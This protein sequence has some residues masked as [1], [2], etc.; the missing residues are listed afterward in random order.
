MPFPRCSCLATVFFNQLSI[1]DDDVPERTPDIKSNLIK[2]ATNANKSAKQRMPRPA[3][4]TAN[5]VHEV[6]GDL[7]EQRKKKSSTTMT[8]GK[9]GIPMRWQPSLHSFPP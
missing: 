4:E 9:I 2:I 5:E 8:A 1:Q 7:N 3:L 6:M